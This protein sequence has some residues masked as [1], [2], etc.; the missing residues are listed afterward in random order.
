MDVSGWVSSLY[1]QFTELAYNVIYKIIDVLPDSPF[2]YI[3]QT[4]EVFKI[5][6]IVNWF[7]PFDFVIST[8]TAWLSAI[9]I[10]YAYTV[11]LRFFKL[12]G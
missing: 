9:A 3:S 2:I 5:L 1:D 7:L 6:K 4:V 10:Y 11:I 12:I 8:F